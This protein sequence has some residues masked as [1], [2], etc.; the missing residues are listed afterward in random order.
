MEIKINDKACFIFDLD[1]TLYLEREYL[2]SA[3]RSIADEIMKLTGRDYFI[4]MLRLYRSGANVFQWIEAAFGT[5]SAS[6]TVHNLLQHYHHH[7]PSISLA[8][9]ARSFLEQLRSMQIPMGL[10]TD[11]RSITQRNKLKALGI[12]DYFSDIIIS[13]EFGSAKPAWRNFRYFQD[14][15]P[16]SNFH[17]FGDNTEKDFLVPGSLGWN[18]Y[19]IKDNGEHI[20]PQT[21]R[22]DLQL[23]LVSTFFEIRL[24]K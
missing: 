17:Y 5:R 6:L 20:H 22:D 18:C 24:L 16:V 11:G 21:F 14:R 3:F 13:E 10:I 9:G 15:Y 23:N 19:C 8:R 7:R 2:H 4:Y 12:D 1:D